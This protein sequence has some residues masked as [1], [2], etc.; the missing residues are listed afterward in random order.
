MYL[1]L[2]QNNKG[3]SKPLWMKIGKESKMTISEWE[4]RTKHSK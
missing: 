1:K 4:R 2:F 3:E